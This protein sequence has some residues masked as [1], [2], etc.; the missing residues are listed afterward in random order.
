[1]L[2]I[3]S[4]NNKK[5][6]D[7]EDVSGFENFGEKF[8]TVTTPYQLTDTGLLKNTDTATIS[9]AYIG[10]FIP[11]SIKKKFLSKQGTIKYVPLSKIKLRKV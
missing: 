8:K 1:M 9:N 6:T 4:C 5:A 7:Q 10:G 3:L 11:D 2:F